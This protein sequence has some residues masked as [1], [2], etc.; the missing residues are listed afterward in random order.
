[1]K[2]DKPCFLYYHLGVT[3]QYLCGVPIINFVATLIKK[4]SWLNR[5]NTVGSLFNALHILYNY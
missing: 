3:L 5:Y 4:R 2:L 1:M